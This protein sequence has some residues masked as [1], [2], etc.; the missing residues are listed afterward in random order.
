MAL[1]LRVLLLSRYGRLGASSRLRTAQYLPF[2]EEQHLHVV[3][4]PFFS[5]EYLAAVHAG[6]RQLRSTLSS[7]Y[8]RLAVLRRQPP[9]DLIWLEYEAVP[10]LPFAVE[11]RFMPAGVPVVSDYDDAIFHRY[12][13]HSR[14][15][16]RWLLARKIDRV[17]ATSHLV[18][19][20][21]AYLAGRARSAGSPLVQIVPTVVDTQSYVVAPPRPS[22]AKRRIGWIGSPSTWTAYM[23]PILPCL[24]SAA[25]EHGARLAVIG[26][27]IAAPDHHLIDHFPWSEETEVERI[28]DMDIG[29]MPLTDTPWARGKCGYKLIQYMACGLPVVASPVGVNTEI[30]EHGVNGFLASTEEEWRTALGTLLSD[31]DLRARMGAQGRRKVEREYSLS[32]WGPKVAGMLR[33]IAART[34]G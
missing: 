7:L 18:T 31:P 23:V 2:L 33:D 21:N 3:S 14:Q 34:V 25:I 27:G 12:D 32:I 6:E 16:V 29:I 26:A 1:S 13:L 22:E 9:P 11:R 4:F 17:M 20:G 5:D 10:W 28:H 19:A 24:T 15:E 30:V 8:E